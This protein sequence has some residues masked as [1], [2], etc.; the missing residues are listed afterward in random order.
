MK[1][2]IT[3]VLAGLLIFSLAACGQKQTN[4]QSEDH[5]E[6]EVIEEAE[7]AEEAREPEVSEAAE[8]AALEMSAAETTT[9][10]IAAQEPAAITGGWTAPESPEVPDEVRTL[11]EKAAQGLVGAEYEPVA[12]IGSQLVAGTNYALLCRITPVVPDAVPHYSIVTLYEDLDGNVSIT[13]TLDSQAEGEAVAGEMTGAWENPESPAMTDA[14]KTALDKATEKLVGAEY[15]PIALLSTQ[16]V[17]GTN[18]SIL[19]QVTPVVP[20]A[21]SSYTIVHVYQDLEGNAEITETFDF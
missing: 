19:C 15:R 1:K 7:T 4:T 6:P 8:E 2:I 17:S 13:E 5:K 9:G 12:Y 20:D 14:A 21:E 3:L 16:L 11:L 18:Y 10:E